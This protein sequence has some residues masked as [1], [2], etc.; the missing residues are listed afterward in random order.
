[1]DK[2]LTLSNPKLRAG[3]DT[4]DKYAFQLHYLLSLIPDLF[5]DEDFN[6]LCYEFPDDI[7]LIWNKNGCL[8][9]NFI[10]AKDL[11]SDLSN[12]EFIK[13]FEHWQNLDFNLEYLKIT[14]RLRKKK[15][16]RARER[17]YRRL[18]SNSMKNRKSMTN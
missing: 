12:S 11:S 1:M 13:I 3:S 14:K 6:S 18:D 10:Q 17:V 2:P 4:L 16:G 15:F 8:R 7:T 9:R 5:D